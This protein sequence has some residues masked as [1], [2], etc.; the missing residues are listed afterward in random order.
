M[1]KSPDYEY[2][3]LSFLWLSPFEPMGI[4]INTLILS[5]FK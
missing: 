4:E 1:Y 3:Q 2:E 5:F